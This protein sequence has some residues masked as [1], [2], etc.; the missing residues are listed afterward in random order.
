[1]SN[2]IKADGD[3][4]QHEVLE[5]EGPVM[6]DFGAVWCSPCKMLDPVVDELAGEWTGAVKV[7]KVDIDTSPDIAFQY[8]IMSVPTLMVFK[9]GQILDRITGYQ[10]KERIIQKFTP[11]FQPA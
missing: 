2:L 3:S 11:H 6:V 1:M 4:F 10:P 5:A 7:V 8:N 9:D